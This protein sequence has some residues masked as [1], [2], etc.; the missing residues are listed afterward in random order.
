MGPQ[1]HRSSD[2]VLGTLTCRTGELKTLKRAQREAT[3]QRD[4][5]DETTL[6]SA[7]AQSRAHCAAPINGRGPWHASPWGATRDPG[8]RFPLLPHAGAVCD[9]RAPSQ[10]RYRVSLPSS[11]NGA[12]DNVS[13]AAALTITNPPRSRSGPEIWEKAYR[14]CIRYATGKAGQ[15]ADKVTSRKRG[16]KGR[17]EPSK[18]ERLPEISTRAIW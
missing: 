13:R 14:M 15:E 7:T 5:R 4:G 1:A 6:P 16:K 12:V 18:M 11:A 8:R 9:G 2:G 3:T 10:A 17:K